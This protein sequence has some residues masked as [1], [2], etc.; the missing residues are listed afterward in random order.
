MTTEDKS[1][2][3][4]VLLKEIALNSGASL[5][6]A[7]GFDYSKAALTELRPGT[8]K[9][10]PFAVSAGA[11]LSGPVLEDIEDHPTKLYQYHYRQ[12]NYLLDRIALLL[13]KYIQ[14]R[15]YNALPIPASQVVGWTPQKGHLSHKE[16]ARLSGLGWIGRNN[17]LVNPEFGSRVRLVSVLTDLPLRADSP[18]EN[19]CGSCRKCVSLC[20]AGAIKETREE[21]DRDSCFGRLDD[22]RKK[23]A[24]GHHICGVCVK[25]CGKTVESGK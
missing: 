22:F 24:L 7:C 21:F 11:R 10:L 23:Y 20:P 16:V 18:L 2:E 25:A 5:F 13:V 15:G 1:G 3:N 12:V 9:A 19:G 17:L 14:E 8:A 4:Y 6:G